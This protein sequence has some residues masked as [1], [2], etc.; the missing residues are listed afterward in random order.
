MAG[1]G[2]A[3]NAPFIAVLRYNRA[4]IETIMRRANQSDDLSEARPRL[5][6]EHSRPH[7]LDGSNRHVATGLRGGSRVE[8][9]S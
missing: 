3:G 2:V 9:R 6:G 4:R 7:R 5:D 8:T 1:A